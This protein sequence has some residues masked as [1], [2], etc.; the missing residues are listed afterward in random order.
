MRKIDLTGKKF[1]H[2]TVLQELGGGKVLCRC[3]CGTIKECDKYK[4]KTGKTK[5]CGCQRYNFVNSGQYKMTNREGEKFNHLTILQELGGD[6]VLCRCDCGNEKILQKNRVVSGYTKSCG[7]LPRENKNVLDLTGKVFGKL[8]VIKKVQSKPVKWLCKCSCGNTT[9]VLTSNLT[10]HKST[11]CN[12]CSGK[13]RAKTMRKRLKKFSIDGTNITLIKNRKL[14]KNNK[15]GT[16]GVFFLNRQDKWEAAIG[17]RN[18]IISLG[19]FDTKEEAIKARKKA[20]EKY[21]EPVI[22]KFKNA[23]KKKEQE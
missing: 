5:S 23:K 8:I 2:L 15:S 16:L 11:S 3:D 7:C 13:N 4:V 9:I 17:I 20:E 19:K 14:G 1:N 22:Q 12:S 6:K 10:H 21:F 18:T